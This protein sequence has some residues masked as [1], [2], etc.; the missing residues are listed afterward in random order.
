MPPRRSTYAHSSDVLGG[1][2]NATTTASDPATIVAPMDDPSTRS[3]SDDVAADRISAAIASGR[4]V[5]IAG[6][7]FLVTA[8][9]A[10]LATVAEMFAV[11][12]EHPGPPALSLDVSDAPAA[13]PDSPPTESYGTSRLWREG[14]RLTF[15]SGCGVVATADSASISVRGRA[16]GHAFAMGV[17][18]SMHHCLAHALS[19]TG[20][21]VLHGAAVAR[22]SAAIL[23][24]GSTGSGKSTCTYLAAAAGWDVIADDLVALWD[25]GGAVLATG[26]PRSLNVP[27]EALSAGDEGDDGDALAGDAR[28]RRRLPLPLLP[29]PRR[30]GAVAII[31]HGRG[32]GHVTPASATDLVRFIVG[33]S[34]AAGHPAVARQAFRLAGPL[35]A[36]PA[37]WLHTGDTADARRSV[38]PEQLARLLDGHR[39]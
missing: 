6:V 27:A 7:P 8:S 19:L 20:R 23:L 22:G 33:S 16:D 2:L 21:A 35:S 32:P 25:S 9:A 1:L 14:D 38:V 12:A 11:A 37:V 30:V 24:L 26:I 18:R 13:A 10:T 28:G 29:E 15:D 36:G 17:R 39:D 4:C 3:V 5:S 31:R 34:P